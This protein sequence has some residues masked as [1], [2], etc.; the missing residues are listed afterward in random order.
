MKSA[1]LAL[2]TLSVL[3]L[4]GTA[5]AAAPWPVRVSAAM[6]QVPTT[7]VAWTTE[8]DEPVTSLDDLS[9]ALGLVGVPQDEDALGGFQHLVDDDTHAYVYTWGGA[10]V[11]DLVYGGT[12]D[13]IEPMSA[14]DLWATSDALLDELGLF[15]VPG[16][17]IEADRLGEHRIQAFDGQNHLLGSWIAHQVVT[18]TQQVDGYPTMG[19]GSEIR[20][21]YGEDGLLTA[22][23]HAVRELHEGPTLRIDSPE[24]AV[25][26]YLDRAGA[27]NRWNLYKLATPGLTRVDL[28]SVEL[29]YYS[30]STLETDPVLEPVYEIKGT[31]YG[32]RGPIGELLWYEP[33]GRGRSIPELDVSTRRVR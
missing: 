21:V 11:H 9:D 17:D 6:P 7:M 33:A 8:A 25:K 12:E 15:D 28:T 3:S 24:V 5:R 22:F 1:F 31:I 4:A 10:A 18:Y 29:G 2:T 16:V 14:D 19:P 20:F 26:R 23:S 27:T 32:A 13:E 30:P